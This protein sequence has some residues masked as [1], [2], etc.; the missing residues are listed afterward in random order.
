MDGFFVAQG[1]SLEWRPGF[2][3]RQDFSIEDSARETRRSVLPERSS[4]SC[5]GAQATCAENAPSTGWEVVQELL[6]VVEE[7]TRDEEL[8]LYGLQSLLYDS[9][10]YPEDVLG[11]PDFTLDS[12]EPQYSSGYSDFHNRPIV[13]QLVTP[14]QGHNGPDTEAQNS[15]V[16]GNLRKCY[17]FWH[18]TLN[19]PQAVL[20]IIA[21]GYI[22]PLKEEPPAKFF[23]NH[24]ICVRHH[25]FVDESVHKLLEGDCIKQ[26]MEIPYIC[27]PLSVV[28]NRKGK[29][30]LVVDLR[31]VNRYIWKCKFKY[32]DLRTVLSMFETGHYVITFDLKAGYHH[33]DINKEHWKYLGF[34]WKGQYYVFSVLPFGLSSAC[35]IFTKVMRPLVRYWRSLGIKAVL[36]IDDGIVGASSRE[37]AWEV[38]EIVASDLA[39][40]GLIIN[41]K[42]SCLV[43]A[44]KCTWLGLE[45]D[46][47]FGR[48]TVGDEKM[49]ALLT[50]INK[51]LCSA[52]V[53]R[54]RPVA[55]VV[56][57]LISMS[58]AIGQYSR[59]FTRN[60]YAAIISRFSW[61]GFVMLDARALSEL[62]FWRDNIQILNGQSMWFASSAVRI[63]YSDASG[64]GYGGYVVEHADK[65]VHG[66]WSIEECRRSSTWRELEA[67]RRVLGHV[68]PLVHGLAIKW[69]TD[70]QNV[71]RILRVGS[72]NALLQAQAVEICSMCA[73]NSLRLEPVWVPREENIRADYISKLAEVDDWALNPVLFHELDLIWGPHTVD[74]FANNENNQTV[75]FNS[76]FWC[77]GTEAVD[78]FTCDWHQENNWLCPP[79]TLI[80]RVLRHMRSCAAIGTLILPG[81][82]SAPFWPLVCPDGCSFADFVVGW[83]ALPTDMSAFLPGIQK[84]AV[85]GLGALA[86]PVFALRICFA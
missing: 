35:Y 58:R 9:V 45:L 63:A 86:F 2:D 24:S 28:K 23:K 52:P 12:I 34:G 25:E 7:S 66:M 85:F 32:E 76:R 80:P 6:P 72:R 5:V 19:A 36:Y 49:E 16:Q 67:V 74:R 82:C 57:Q 26:V 60:L 55:G 54:A 8:S 31:F 13:C 39:K 17:N 61:D 77:L 78:A 20:E 46:F 18:N 29:L 50:C 38:A 69:L 21:S 1:S 65:I 41:K 37:R 33:I 62:T 51:L 40:A 27:N 53:V 68:A 30:R 79:P 11:I 47:E 48:I 71:T 42:K 83:M 10:Y 64:F 44:Q 59:L 73:E 4:A 81:W 75:R 3:T 14:G 22:L 70:N 56:G 43:P 15:H 84:H